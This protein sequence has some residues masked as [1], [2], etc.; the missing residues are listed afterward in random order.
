[1]F[2]I[3]F[4][5]VSPYPSPSDYRNY[6]LQPI[7]IHPWAMKASIDHSFISKLSLEFVLMRQKTFTPTY[8]VELYTHNVQAQVTFIYWTFLCAFK[9]QALTGWENI[10][11]WKTRVRIWNQDVFFRVF[12]VVSHFQIFSIIVLFQCYRTLLLLS[13][14]IARWQ[15][16]VVEMMLL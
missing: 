16:L 13:C 3:L 11:K 8:S 1:M 10:K 14:I 15:P 6:Y 5:N 7:Q 12:L 2:T 9:W 4:W